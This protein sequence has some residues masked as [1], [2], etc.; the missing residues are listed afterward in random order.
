[1]AKERLNCPYVIVGLQEVRGETV[2][3]G[4]GGDPL[5]ELRPPDSLELN[6]NITWYRLNRIE[7]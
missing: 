4:V 1:M 5:R 6:Q 2:A 3:K 7:I